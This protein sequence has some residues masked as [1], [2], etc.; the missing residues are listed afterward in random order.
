MSIIK[1]IKSLS[2]IPKKN[3]AT[4]EMFAPF[5]VHVG[6]TESWN[7]LHDVH[8]RYCGMACISMVN[9]SSMRVC[10]SAMFHV[11]HQF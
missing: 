6:T 1:L 5:T 2:V 7:N 11:T 8:L 9:P 10:M 4:W 3:R